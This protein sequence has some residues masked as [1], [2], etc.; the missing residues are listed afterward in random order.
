MES[1][2]ETNGRAF[3]FGRGPRNDGLEFDSMCGHCTRYFAWGL[4][5]TLSRVGPGGEESET[6]TSGPGRRRWSAHNP[7][8]FDTQSD[9]PEPPGR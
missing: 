3:H 8:Q 4:L 7:L 1:P 6:L 2:T 9:Q 5:G